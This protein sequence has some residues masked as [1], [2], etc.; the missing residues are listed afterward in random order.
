MEATARQSKVEGRKEKKRKEGKL[1]PEVSRE[2]ETL[3]QQNKEGA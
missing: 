1:N 3:C 2:M